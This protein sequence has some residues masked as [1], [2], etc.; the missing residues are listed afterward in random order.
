[1]T[2]SALQRLHQ[3][4]RVQALLM[5]SGLKPG[6]PDF[7]KLA[8]EL[9]PLDIGM[10]QDTVTGQRI[11]WMPGRES[12]GMLLIQGASGS[13][14]TQALIRVGSDIVHHAYPVLVLDFHGDVQFPG[15]N[16][17]A[18]SAGD[19]GW[20]GINPMAVFGDADI[21]ANLYEQRACLVDMLHRAI[22]RLSAQQRMQLQ[23]AIAQ[24]YWHAG[25]R[26]NDPSTWNHP[27]PCFRDV[28]AILQHWLHHP[29]KKP[30][31]QS[32]NGCIAAIRSQFDHPVFSK[33]DT[34]DS[35]TL[36]RWNV[37]VDFSQI[38]SDSV[39]FI[40]A[41]A[42]LR[43][44]FQSLQRQGPIATDAPDHER[45]RLFVLIDEA[46][47]ITQGSGDVEA[48]SNI[49]NVIAT[50]GRKFGMGLILASQ[51]SGHF[52][53]EITANASARLIMKPMSLAEAR[54]SAADISIN[55]LALLNLR[56]GGDGYFHSNVHASARLIQVSRL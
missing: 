50:E 43:Q 51:M 12:N 6:H 37:R 7:L 25:F 32:L 34:F 53:Q 4:L 24:A 9:G 33:R 48:R 17:Y 38:Q 49:L 1:M 13:G 54:R 41:Q 52:G 20:V 11:D 44:V 19:N 15:L 35:E 10:G 26:D 31:R 23:D 42:L 28:V 30:V 14:K 45:F 21:H 39:R 55:P 36:L 47:L 2:S 27:A 56:G 3:H 5:D 16:S 40:A 18:L 8:S 22:P 46:K 29:A